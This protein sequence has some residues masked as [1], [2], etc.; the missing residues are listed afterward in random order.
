MDNEKNTYKIHDNSDLGEVNINDNV[1]AVIS[2]M[3][4]LE[5]DG[6]VG[7]AGNITSEIV[8]KLGMKK[9]S[10]GVRVDVDEKNVMIDVSIVLKMNDNIVEISKKVQDKIKNTVE[11]MTGLEVVNVNVNISNVISD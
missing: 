9:I 6:V 3:A 2:A 8:E 5:V 1:L 10:K 4:A 11:N 7:M